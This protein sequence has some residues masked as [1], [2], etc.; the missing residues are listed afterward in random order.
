MDRQ[1]ITTTIHFHR[2][3]VTNDGF[4]LIQCLSPWTYRS[5]HQSGRCL[6]GQYVISYPTGNTTDIHRFSP[7]LDTTLPLSD[8]QCAQYLNKTMYRR[9]SLLRIAG[10]TGFTSRGQ[11]ES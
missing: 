5:K 10:V 7:Q 2:S 6:R 3:A 1:R 8:E 9:F 4:E 11:S